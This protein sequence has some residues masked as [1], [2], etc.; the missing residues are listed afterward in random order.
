MERIRYF[1]K[2]EL[3]PAVLHRERSPDNDLPHTR[4]E[5]L[6]QGEG[7]LP[8]LYANRLKIFCTYL[9]SDMLINQTQC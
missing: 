7:E 6:R 5:I 4:I 1:Q 8:A 9:D 2:Q 3:I